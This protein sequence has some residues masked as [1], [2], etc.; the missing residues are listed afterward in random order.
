MCHRASARELYHHYCATGAFDSL[1][2]AG[3]VTAYDV[4]V[5]V[6]ISVGELWEFTRIGLRAFGEGVN[7]A[8][9]R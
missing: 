3:F 8:E 7:Y 5:R 4:E 9:N 1:F 2:R 6:S